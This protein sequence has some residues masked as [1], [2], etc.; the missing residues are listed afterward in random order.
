MRVRYTRSALRD[1]DAILDHISTVNEAAARSVMTSVDLVVARLAKYPRSAPE[2]EQ[3]GVRM[4]PIPR[5]PYVTFCT[6]EDE[7]ISIIHVRH[8]ARR[9]PWE[10]EH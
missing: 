4:A 10:N 1:I 6:I 2:T 9:R 5:H 8:G 3:L 7:E